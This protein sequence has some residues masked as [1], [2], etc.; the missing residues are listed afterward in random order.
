MDKMKF[1]D[2]AMEWSTE[3]GKIPP[4]NEMDTVEALTW[5]FGEVE[6]GRNPDAVLKEVMAKI[7]EKIACRS[8]GLSPAKTAAISSKL[9]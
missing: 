1:F 4:G 7:N 8:D 3:V 5:G 9:N 2:M 6:R